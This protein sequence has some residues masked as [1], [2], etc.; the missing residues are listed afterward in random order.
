MIH[1]F[2]IL[3]IRATE[4][5]AKLG[6]ATIM[7][8]SIEKERLNISR[9]DQKTVD[10]LNKIFDF[11]KDNELL[12]GEYGVSDVVELVT[13][14]LSNEGFA[15]KLKNIELP[16]ELRYKSS[17]NNVFE[18]II[19]YIS[20]LVED[21]L[22]LGSTYTDDNAL[23]SI[24]AIINDFGSSYSE[25]D[26]QS[27]MKINKAEERAREYFK[28]GKSNQS[29]NLGSELTKLQ[30]LKQRLAE[31]NKK[32]DEVTK[33]FNAQIAQKQAELKV[34]EQSL[35]ETTKAE[36]TTP[37]GNTSNE[38]KR[39]DALERIGV[40][41][42]APDGLQRKEWKEARDYDLGRAIS[43]VENQLNANPN[44]KIGSIP[45]NAANAI[46][47]ELEMVGVKT[48]DKTPLSEIIDKIKAVEQSLKEQPKADIDT[49]KEAGSVGV[50]GELADED[51]I[52]RRKKNENI[53]TAPGSTYYSDVNLKNSK[54][55]DEI[56]YE[57]YKDGK[58]IKHKTKVKDIVG[59]EVIFEN[60][61]SQKDVS[62][63]MN[64]TAEDAWF[65]KN[66]K[67]SLK[68][69]P[70]AVSKPEDDALLTLIKKHIKGDPSNSIV[71][72]Q[73]L[74]YFIDKAGEA[75]MKA[76]REFGGVDVVKELLSRLSIEKLQENYDFLANID[77]TSQDAL[78]LEEI[79]IKL[80]K[81]GKIVIPAAAS[82]EIVAPKVDLP[83][84]QELKIQLEA[85]K[86]NLKT[87]GPMVAKAIQVKIDQ[88]EKQLKEIEKP[89]EDLSPLEKL[90]AIANEGVAQQQIPSIVPHIFEGNPFKID[91]ENDTIEGYFE[92]SGKEYSQDFFESFNPAVYK[93][94]MLK[95]NGLNFYFVKHNV[96]GKFVTFDENMRTYKVS[97]LPKAI[98]ESSE[99]KNIENCN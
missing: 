76:V 29:D 80:K 90:R 15:E 89:K 39:G 73:P 96:L 33:R 32:I 2:T 85:L 43:I 88:I 51:R 91:F 98:L 84:D 45:M 36:T 30:Q 60:G 44:S 97:E 48:T 67:Q 38:E 53:T 28:Y 68:E 54:I 77:A 31:V 19:L 59:G 18:N 17:N 55:G 35:K 87:V 83:L 95:N 7:N 6:L 46:R 56:H 57:E 10:S 66:Q 75:P 94:A 23:E 74:Q 3:K 25:S 69:Q 8:P 50:G 93:K 13:E 49:K 52:E 82:E 21:L 37:K 62:S 12:K 34:L 9:S 16:K 26:Q 40:D 86:E 20:K 61:Q 65:A 58:F 41:R 79:I 78:A 99:F 24:A 5:N 63:Y 4:T 92:D 47:A 72:R 42:Q 81:T 11:L 1:A 14:A 22:N 70:K 64:I 71:H 27:F